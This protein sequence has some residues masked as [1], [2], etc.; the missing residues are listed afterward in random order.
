MA[1]N[2]P[3]ANPSKPTV[4]PTAIAVVWLGPPPPEDP[5]LFGLLVGLEGSFVLDGGLF[6]SPGVDVLEGDPGCV[7]LEGEP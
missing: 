1:A 4:V 3:A 6:G 5:L 2:A 7:A